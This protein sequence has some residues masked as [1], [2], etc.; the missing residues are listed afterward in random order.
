M[1]APVNLF[2]DFVEL[3]SITAYG[4]SIVFLKTSSLLWMTELVFVVCNG[5]WVT[6]QSHSG[7]KDINDE[8]ISVCYCMAL[9]KW[10]IRL[11][12]SDAVP[13]VS[14]NNWFKS[15]TNKMYVLCSCD[16]ASWAKHEERIPTRCNNIN[17][18]LS[19]PDVDYWL[20]SRHVSGIFM[21]IVRRKDHVLLHMGF[22]LVVLD[23]AG[24]GVVVLRCRVWALWRLLFE[25]QP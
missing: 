18:L 5:S 7:T 20:L 1:N 10:Q 6:L 2:S 21:P 23:V 4:F 3:K 9:C 12:V 14:W 16:R 13:T 24:C 11:S 17:D 19:I 25:Q 8:R 22:L 15:F